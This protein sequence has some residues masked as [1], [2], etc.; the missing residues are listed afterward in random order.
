V[1]RRAHRLRRGPADDTV[2]L[3]VT[4][5]LSGLGGWPRLTA[6]ILVADV[7]RSVFDG[8]ETVALLGPS[9]VAVLA[10]R[11]DDIATRAVTVRREVNGQVLTDP[12]LRG[13]GRPQIRVLRLRPTFAETCAL[14]SQ[15]SRA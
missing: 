1:Y 4:I 5:D 3:A 8:G 6:M 11:D 15:I 9:T 12:Q 13:L 7:L 2:L 10:D 14:L